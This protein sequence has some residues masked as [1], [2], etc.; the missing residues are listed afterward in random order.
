M[1]WYTSPDGQPETAYDYPM[2]TIPHTTIQEFQQEALYPFED[3][4]AQPL[5]WARETNDIIVCNPYPNNT[6]ARSKAFFEIYR[7]PVFPTSDTSNFSTGDILT[8]LFQYKLAEFLA[9]KHLGDMEQAAVLNKLYMD[10]FKQQQISDT[11]S[12][13]F[14]MYRGGRVGAKTWR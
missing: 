10:F 14:T 3:N 8:N 12:P 13:S 9:I 5:V 2:C 1:Y 7:Y 6:L 4:A 11:G